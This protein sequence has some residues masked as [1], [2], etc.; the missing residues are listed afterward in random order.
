MKHSALGIFSFLQPFQKRSWS[1]LVQEVFD[2]ISIP[3]RWQKIYSNSLPFQWEDDHM[4]INHFNIFFAGFSPWFS[5]V[6]GKPHFPPRA[7]AGAELRCAALWLWL[8]WWWTN[9][10]C[11]RF[12][13]RHG[14]VKLQCFDV[15]VWFRSA[16]SG[17]CKLPP[18][19]R[20][21][22]LWHPDLLRLWFFVFTMVFA[23]R[24]I[25]DFRTLLGT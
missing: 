4:M 9:P 19:R 20:G 2:H 17:G 1:G 18:L 5:K 3:D 22:W 11:Q 6:L 24:W 8:G 23:H 21:I 15:P 25:V 13:L 16:I 7:G 10:M 14:H 12:G